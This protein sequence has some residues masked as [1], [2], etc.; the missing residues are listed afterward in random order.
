MVGICYPWVSLN[1]EEAFY[2]ICVTSPTFGF[3]EIL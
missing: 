1:E 2:W 3:R